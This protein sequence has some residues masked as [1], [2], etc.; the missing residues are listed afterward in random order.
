[1]AEGLRVG[2]LHR[3]ERLTDAIDAARAWLAEHRP[4]PYDHTRYPL[5]AYKIPGER[6]WVVRIECENTPT[7]TARAKSGW[8]PETR[9]ERVP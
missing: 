7:P 1:M 9:G 2:P 3:A 6:Q 4:P 8:R 5:W